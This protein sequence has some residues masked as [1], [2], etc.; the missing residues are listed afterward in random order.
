MMGCSLHRHVCRCRSPYILSTDI[1]SQIHRRPITWQSIFPRLSSITDVMII[2]PASFDIIIITI[3]HR[4]PTVWHICMHVLDLMYGPSRSTSSVTKPAL[5]RHS[6]YSR[7]YSGMVRHARATR[8]TPTET[9]FRY[10][11]E[12]RPIG[13]NVGGHDRVNTI[14]QMTELEGPCFSRIGVCRSKQGRQRVG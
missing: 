9:R 4:N 7:G 5:H 6:T 8:P 2:L 3:S 13:K 12:P 14:R 11:W 10:V 1:D